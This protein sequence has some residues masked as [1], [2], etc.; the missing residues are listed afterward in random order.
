MATPVA[1]FVTVTVALGTVAPEESITLPAMAPRST[2]PDTDVTHRTSHAN[3]RQ[4][5]PDNFRVPRPSFI[6][7]STF[8][9]RRQSPELCRKAARNYSS[10][11]HL[12]ADCSSLRHPTHHLTEMVRIQFRVGLQRRGGGRRIRIGRSRNSPA[13]HPPLERSETIRLR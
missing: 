11:L 10:S 7:A 5:I 4:A 8:Q 9:I 3:N 13:N 6:A 1:L 2:C 12:P